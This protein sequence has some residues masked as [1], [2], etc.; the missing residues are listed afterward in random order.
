M[1]SRLVEGSRGQQGLGPGR[2]CSSSGV[3]GSTIKSSGVGDSGVGSS[4]IRCSG[5]GGSSRG[6]Q[7]AHSGLRRDFG[8]LSHQLFATV[9]VTTILCPYGIAYRRVLWVSVYG[10]TTKS[11]GI[12]VLCESD[13]WLGIIRAC[14]SVWIHTGVQ[15][16]VLSWNSVYSSD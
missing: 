13:A 14:F 9:P 3:G 6:L 2:S 5:V 8:W 7:D 16:G 11:I 1:S 10:F 12:S 4:T 15:V